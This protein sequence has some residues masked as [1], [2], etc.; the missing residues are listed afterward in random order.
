MSDKFLYNSS[1]VFG[2]LALLLLLVNICLVNS[3]R[4]F[5]MELVQRQNAITNSG[6]QSQ[7]NNALVQA[8]AQA[9][10][11]DDN[12]DIR[13]LLSAQGITAKAKPAAASAASA[14][15][16]PAADKKK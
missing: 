7:L 8:L 12:K 4:N 10:V 15:A 3:N 6:P 9:S 16:A 11:N 5:Q 14:P 13:D 2:T 1:M